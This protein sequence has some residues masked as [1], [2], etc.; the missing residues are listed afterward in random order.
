MKE[1]S[2]FL[3]ATVLFV[4]CT[5]GAKVGVKDDVKK[6]A[7]DSMKPVS[8]KLA[9]YWMHVESRTNPKPLNE[10]WFIT[11]NGTGVQCTPDTPPTNRKLIVADHG[12]IVI[13]DMVFKIYR[14]SKDSFFAMRKNPPGSI[15]FKR[16]KK[17][18]DAC[19]EN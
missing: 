11:A 18:L 7:P 13:N 1:I 15:Y 5:S 10:Q 2:I 9:G 14:D 12:Y 16:I 6:W 19:K 4:G 17:S 8:T 3:I